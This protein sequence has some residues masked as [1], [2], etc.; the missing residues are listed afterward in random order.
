MKGIIEMAV[1]S[2]FQGIIHEN[3]KILKKTLILTIL[4]FSI[5]AKIYAERHQISTLKLLNI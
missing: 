3:E 4:I 2:E 1:F 5:I